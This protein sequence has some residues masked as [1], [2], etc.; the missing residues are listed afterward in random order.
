VELVRAFRARFDAEHTRDGEIDGALERAL[1]RA[2]EAWPELAV[3]E[4][5]FG[6]RLAASVAATPVL[7]AAIDQLAAADLFFTLACSTGDAIALATLDRTYL[8][9]LRGI[10]GKLG[11]DPAGVDDTLQT[12][13]EELLA[14]SPRI[15]TYAGRGPLHGWLRSVAVRTGLRLLRT[16]TQ[17]AE[18]DDRVHAPLADDLELAYMKKTYGEAFQHAF[19]AALAALDAADR[20]L[21]KQRFRHRLTLDELGVV[22]A[23]NASTISRWVTAARERL[24]TN[25]RAEMMRALGVGGADLSSIL[26]LIE[27]ELEITLSLSS[28]VVG[29]ET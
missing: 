17:H 12:M 25:T 8:A 19:R 5:R 23:V 14:A 4:V 11:L 2:R 6:E 13:R 29:G 20:V 18:L 26:R 15:L 22:H 27:S 9:P 16:T 10:I 21:L 1:Q 28:E 7:A 24:V 3:D